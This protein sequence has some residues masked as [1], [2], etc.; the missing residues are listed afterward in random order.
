MIPPRFEEINIEDE[1]T[2]LIKKFTRENIIEYGYASG[3]RNPIH[4]SDPAAWQAGLR[5]VIAHGLFFAAFTH[6]QLTDWLGSPHDLKTTNV[7]FIGSCRPGDTV[8]SEASVTGKNET[9]RTVD[10]ELK[11]FAHTPLI[12]GKITLTDVSITD[13]ALKENL[14]NAKLKLDYSCQLQDGIVKEQS[15]DIKFEAKGIEEV[16]YVSVEEGAVKRWANSKESIEV[17]INRDGK[18]VE[19]T[20]L[21]VRQSIYGTAT[22][23]LP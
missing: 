5:G 10:L 21:R 4:M 13:I 2:P 14:K 19:F 7:K 6:Q 17:E 20:I 18:D 22:V 11:Q 1:I 8:V 23:K 15:A 16:H 12:F 9:E 3:D